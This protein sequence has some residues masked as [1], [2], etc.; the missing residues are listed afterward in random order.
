MKMTTLILSLSVLLLAEGGITTGNA[1][2]RK[3]CKN[4]SGIEHFCWKY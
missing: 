3:Y 4:I 1:G 2:G